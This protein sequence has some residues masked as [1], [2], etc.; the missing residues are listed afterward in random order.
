MVV[1]GQRRKICV[2]RGG[3]A[4]RPYSKAV[5]NW[6]DRVWDFAQ[7]V[8]ILLLA[9]AAGRTSVQARTV[10]SGSKHRGCVS[11]CANT[12]QPKVPA[13]AA[14]SSCPKAATSQ[15]SRRGTAKIGR[16]SCRERGSI[17]V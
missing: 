17:S 14:S 13:T 8:F 10:L 2:R 11:A 6:K 7:I 15:C 4:L 9:T 1:V 3:R 12:T 5:D 16:A